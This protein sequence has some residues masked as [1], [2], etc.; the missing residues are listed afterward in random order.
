MLADFHALP[1][2]ARLLR[3]ARSLFA[4]ASSV[5]KPLK[6]S[7]MVL[8]VAIVAALLPK[9]AWA[10]APV[11]GSV[12]LTSQ[13]GP[14]RTY[15]EEGDTVL[16]T[17]TFDQAVYVTG[18]PSID[19]KLGAS[20]KTASYQS[21]S[22]STRLVFG[23]T[24]GPGDSAPV[25][26]A[27]EAGAIALNGGTL[28]NQG[29]EAALL[30]HP[31][32]APDVAH[33]VDRRCVLNA[34]LVS[35]SGTFDIATSEDCLIPV[36]SRPDP[37]GLELH[38]RVP[39]SAEHAVVFVSGDS[40][41][42]GLDTTTVGVENGTRH[43]VDD[44]IVCNALRECGGNDDYHA[45]FRFG[46]ADVDA[47]GNH[48]YAA[49]QYGRNPGAFGTATLHVTLVPR[50]TGVTVA[51]NSCAASSALTWDAP[52]D[53]GR[54][55]S[56]VVLLTQ[57]AASYPKRRGRPDVYHATGP[58]VSL[59]GL[60][61]D[62]TYFAKVLP[63]VEVLGAGGYLE[64]GR[65]DNADQVSFTVPSPPAFPVPLDDLVLRAE[66]PLA[67]GGLALPSTSGDCG[68]Y[69][70]ALCRTGDVA[71]GTCANVVLPAGLAFDAASGALTGTPTAVA[72]EARYLYTVRNSHGHAVSGEFSLAVA[73]P[74]GEDD[75]IPAVS[76]L[77]FASQ[78]A[79]N[80]QAYADS[81][82]VSL[83]V[84]FDQPVFVSR[85]PTV[86]LA[87]GSDERQLAYAGGSGTDTLTFTYTVA[88][89]D[90]DADGVS[91]AANAFDL[92]GGLVVSAADR[93]VLASLSHE[94]LDGGAG[95]QVAAACP[96]Q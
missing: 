51:V 45:P 21:G 52:P 11:V 91:V 94:A 78:P 9:V 92:A 28:Q 73:G 75:T 32:L 81:E 71:D 72:S 93:T 17:V 96:G 40:A 57:D 60:T 79:N 30:D 7:A 65:V 46:A 19:L 3:H 82:A 55:V 61:A 20:V 34:G 63:Q 14:D 84:V 86:T 90:A 83:E 44:G 74:G 67:E 6:A 27:L 1:A 26:V 50:V 43:G 85:R 62:Q 22:G 29:G 23:Y 88:N 13:S 12:A 18:T 15:G 76:S 42:P 24:V 35:L 77:R 2:S 16:A 33:R 47:A 87:L 53:L 80:S 69:A 49:Y 41:H 36:S 59:A 39:A 66:T 68:P 48:V 31:A 70:Y 38:W 58:T 89:C 56:W 10:A 8:V 64:T 25:G 37:P 95:Q 4:E 54:A 5:P